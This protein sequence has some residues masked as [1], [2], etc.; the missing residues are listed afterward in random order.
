MA[1]A[2]RPPTITDEKTL[3]KLLE[4]FEWGMNQKDAAKYAGIAPQT[5]SATLR[6]GRE[7]DEEMAR[8]RGAGG[9]KAAHQRLAIRKLLQAGGRGAVNH[10]GASGEVG[11]QVAQG[12]P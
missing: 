5:L 8:G 4:A 9:Q 7:A 2:G 11:Y 1:D 10:G 6:R 3:K 12:R